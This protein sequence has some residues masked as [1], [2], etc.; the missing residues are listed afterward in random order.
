MLRSTNNVYMVYE[1]CSGGTLEDKIKQSKGGMD[2][3][4]ALYIIAQI[5]KAF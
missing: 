2:E 4:Q 5:V 1:Y 3:S